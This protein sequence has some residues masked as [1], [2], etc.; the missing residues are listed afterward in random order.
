MTRM[1]SGV[2]SIHRSLP[3][4]AAISP[5]RESAK[6]TRV[7]LPS[8]LDLIS[9]R[10]RLHCAS[11][12]VGRK[13]GTKRWDSGAQASPGWRPSISLSR[14]VPLLQHPPIKIARAS[15]RAEGSK[16]PRSLSAPSHRRYR[17]L[18][19]IL[20]GLNLEISMGRPEDSGGHR[21]GKGLWVCQEA[22]SGGQAQRRKQEY[23]GPAVGPRYETPRPPLMP[24][25]EE[26]VVVRAD[27]AAEGFSREPHGDPVPR[28]IRRY[29]RAVIKPRITPGVGV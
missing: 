2:L 9:R 21:F 24:Q 17:R 7:G 12:R 8:I 6:S 3:A 25:G 26:D 16:K 11:R 29:L 23:R 28:T 14:E 1:F 19:M 18:R 20:R 27:R 22:G 10:T 15:L 4:D 5:K 13:G